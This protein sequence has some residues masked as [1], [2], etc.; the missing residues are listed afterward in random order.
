MPKPILL[1]LED[2]SRASTPLIKVAANM[3]YE[4]QLAERV[5]D[6]LR[7]CET[8]DCIS[9]AIV[10]LRIGEEDVTFTGG[11]QFLEK[12]KLAPDTQVIIFTGHQ[13][14]GNLQVEPPK[15]IGVS[16][17]F[18]RKGLGYE[19]VFKVLRD[20]LVRH[21][22]KQTG[23]IVHES[24]ADKSRL[25]DFPMI[26]ASGLP[27]LI[28]GPSGCG[29]ENE[30]EKLARMSL[31]ISEHHRIHTVNC[32]ALTENI[33][34]ATLFGYVPG[35]YTGASGKGDKGILRRISGTMDRR[36]GGSS[37]PR[38][39]DLPGILILDELA[40]L[41]IFVQAQMLRMLQG[42]TINALG[43]SGPGYTPVVRIIACTNDEAKL[44]KPRKFR[45]DLLGRLDGWHIIVPPLH[46]S[47]R[48]PT[49]IKAAQTEATGWSMILEFG[50]PPIKIWGVADDVA[51]EVA[52][53][54]VPP[55]DGGLRFGFRELNAWVGRACASALYRAKNDTQLTAS[56]LRNAWDKRMK[57]NE[58]DGDA[59]G[60]GEVP[61]MPPPREEKVAAVR[62]RFEEIMVAA[63][64]A[65]SHGSWDE[66]ELRRIATQLQTANSSAYAQLVALKKEYTN[67]KERQYL[68]YLAINGTEAS[69]TQLKNF[70]VNLRQFLGAKR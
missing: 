31:P 53:K 30:A 10:D 60:K 61:P 4:V 25:A 16:Y 55:S 12:A 64:A 62:R 29:K 24:D 32:A 33:A 44:S 15:K 67:T 2:E 5:A 49:V 46:D 52:T 35:A 38:P 45:Q 70:V 42:Q 3:G 57:L 36:S 22:A 21:G 8:V 26:A 51:D 58:I 65:P 17:C 20:Q 37:L 43:D 56:D 1:I 34:I 69:T 13:E 28:T 7:Y 23:G 18:F 50:K 54:L 19:P 40:E 47:Q 68:L 9:V 66:P 6:A 11:W 39:C 41:P 27:V 14:P 63:G 59:S 48:R